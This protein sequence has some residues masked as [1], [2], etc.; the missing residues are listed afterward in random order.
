MKITKAQLKQ[1]IKEELTA[2]QQNTSLQLKTLLKRLED[3]RELIRSGDIDKLGIAKA[4]MDS[5]QL[6]AQRQPLIR[7]VADRM[8]GK[9]R[10]EFKKAV[11]NWER[12]NL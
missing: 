7:D 5:I 10:D 11:R 12:T 2:A 4:K 1:I 3:V 8:I 9:L 6:G